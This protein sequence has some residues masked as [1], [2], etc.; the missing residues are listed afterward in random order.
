MLKIKCSKNIYIKYMI[1]E[2]CLHAEILTQGECTLGPAQL[3]WYVRVLQGKS[4]HLH[5]HLI[6]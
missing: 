3:L 1:D 6:T 2:K 5:E 4:E